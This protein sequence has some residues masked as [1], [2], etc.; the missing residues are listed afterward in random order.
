MKVAV[1]EPTHGVAPHVSAALTQAGHHSLALAASPEDRYDI[2]RAVHDCDAVVYLP[3]DW[4]PDAGRHETRWVAAIVRELEGSGKRFL[5]LSDASVAGPTGEDAANE[6]TG[7]SKDSPHP[8]RVDN[9]RALAAAVWQN[10]HS[11]VL[12]PA[13]LYGSSGTGLVARLVAYADQMG[14]AL[15]VGDGSARTSTVHID[16]LAALIVA[17]LERAPEGSSF[18]AASGEV[19]TWRQVAGWVAGSR[20]NACQLRSISADVA[21]AAGL[22]ADLMTTDCVVNDDSPRR[23]LRWRPSGPPLLSPTATA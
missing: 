12:R 13:L 22:D 7:L 9:E 20:G 1:V 6:D 8:W 5:Y 19:V 3:T 21:T 18:F 17:A 15:Y 16:D 14:E 23:R 11:I 2:R 4:T 10:V